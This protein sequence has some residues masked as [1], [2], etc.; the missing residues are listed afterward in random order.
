M[1]PGDV[2]VAPYG[3]PPRTRRF[4][5][6][7]SLMDVVVIMA[8]VAALSAGALGIGT[9]LFAYETFIVRTGSMAP[10]MPAGSVAVAEPVAPITLKEGD[11]ITYR[12]P[13]APPVTIT[14]RIVYLRINED[15]KNPAPLIRTQGD[16]NAVPDPWQI[17]LYGVA[18]RVVFWVPW[19]GYVFD[20]AHEPAGQIGLVLVPGTLLA[21]Y[22]VV[23]AWRIW[24]RARR[25]QAAAT[26]QT[27]GAGTQWPGG[28][29]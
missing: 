10:A 14:H 1:N 20:M 28:R 17:E 25:E 2:M 26:A 4:F 27:Y 6:W 22:F 24:R 7:R 19:L 9:R 8:C 12:R 23:G 21:G 15:P 5:G 16:A 13:V 29:S 18:W 11:I 3:P